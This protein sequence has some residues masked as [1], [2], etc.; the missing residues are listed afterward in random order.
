M[1]LLKNDNNIKTAIN[2]LSPELLKEKLA[3]LIEI[4]PILNSL[5]GHN[6]VIHVPFETIANDNLVV[7]FVKELNFL[8]Q[9]EIDVVLVPQIIPDSTAQIQSLLPENFKLNDSNLNDA[10][11]ILEL[12]LVSKLVKAL[13]IAEC[14]ALAISGNDSMS[15]TGS[16]KTKVTL[17][18]ATGLH[19]MKVDSKY[20]KI[21]FFNTDIINDLLQT[22]IMPIVI[23]NASNS[24]GNKKYFV[25]SVELASVISH[26]LSAEKLIIGLHEDGVHDSD[27]NLITAVGSKDVF[28]FNNDN[29]NYATEAVLNDVKSAHL[30][31]LT[32]EYSLIIEVFTKQGSGTMVYH[33]S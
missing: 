6:I 21:D 17:N 28:K 9:F 2:F 25:N 19:E 1:D 3:D 13:N 8:R 15:V 33:N 12:C 7:G 22:E 29:L 24:S 30:I 31:N 11:D 4:I 20:A 23:P 27:G 32:K 14:S 16:V 26:K 10:Y 5:S 18:Q